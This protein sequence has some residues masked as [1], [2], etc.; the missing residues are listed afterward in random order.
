MSRQTDEKNEKC[1]EQRAIPKMK[2][3]RTVTKET[4]KNKCTK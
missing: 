3:I 4:T 2:W 1:L